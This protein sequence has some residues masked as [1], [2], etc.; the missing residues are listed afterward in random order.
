M[1]VINDL[2]EPLNGYLFN[3]E[4]NYEMGRYEVQIGIPK[5]WTY[6]NGNKISCEVLRENEKGFL[7]KIFSEHEDVYID[8]LIVFGEKIVSINKKL[9][10]EKLEFDKFLEAKKISLENEVKEFYDKMEKTKLNAFKGEST[11]EAD[12]KEQPKKKGSK[13]EVKSE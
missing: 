3:I 8:D 6:E 11:E 1:S 12:L 2:L 13:T 9:E 5:N 4:R 7:I 10:E